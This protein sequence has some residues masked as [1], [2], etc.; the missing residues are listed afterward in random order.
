MELCLGTVQLGMEYGI[1]GNGRPSHPE[2]MRILSAALEHGIGWFDTAASY[3]GAEDVLGAYI[4][5]H[6]EQAD[7]MHIVS[8][9]APNALSNAPHSEWR[10]IVLKQARESLDRLHK[11]QLD[12][13]MFHN[14][15]CIFEPEAVEA[16]YSACQEGLSKRIGVSIYTPAEAMQALS[17]PQI[18][19]IQVPYN[20]FDRR[21]D[22]CGFF[23]AARKKNV[24]VYARSS[25][26]QGL[27][28][29]EPEMLPAHMKFAA[30]YIRRFRLICK[31]LAVSP[32]EASVGFVAS[33]PD[34][35]YLVFGTDNE[36][37]LLEYAVMAAKPLSAE[38]LAELGHAF[39]TVEEKL[40]NPSLW[41]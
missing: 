10:G 16:L 20:V 40:V 3:G 19:A 12:V 30:P 7:R 26:L 8:K 6:L 24:R 37:Q 29:M 21:L 15:A 33:H 2:R 35:Q 28:A 39:D 17:Y 23:I 5:E 31:G 36:K 4:S 22:L 1:Q 34:I 9:L 11:R 14:A 18:G 38:A 13:Y 32:L 27:A 25:L 41:N